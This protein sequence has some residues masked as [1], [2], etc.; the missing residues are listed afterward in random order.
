MESR[1][2]LLEVILIVVDL[3]LVLNLSK[4]FSILYVG[5]QIYNQL[6]REG[7]KSVF[8]GVESY[9]KT[10]T[11]Q[12]KYSRYWKSQKDSMYWICS[13]VAGCLVFSLYFS[14]LIPLHSESPVMPANWPSP[15][16]GCCVVLFFS[17]STFFWVFLS[18]LKQIWEQLF[19][20]NL[21]CQVKLLTHL[22][23]DLQL[24]FLFSI[25][26]LWNKAGAVAHLCSQ[27]I[28]G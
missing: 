20:H 21:A 1:S 10:S 26:R 13:L 14:C 2:F 23:S 19:F 18:H 15:S 7:D 8:L 3:Q 4:W 5:G 9:P 22:F 12:G 16:H 11:T 17:Q 25:G 24:I 28:Y 27:E 6:A